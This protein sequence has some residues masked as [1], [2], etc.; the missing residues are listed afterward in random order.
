M[1]VFLFADP[2]GASWRR[3]CLNAD[4]DTGTLSKAGLVENENAQAMNLYEPGS[5]KVWT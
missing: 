4:E 5:A 2:S 1:M 3:Q